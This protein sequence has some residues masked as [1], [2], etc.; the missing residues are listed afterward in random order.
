MK[1]KRVKAL[2]L[3][4]AVALTAVCPVA[5][6]AYGKASE[7]TITF[8]LSSGEKEQYYMDYADN[9]II[10]F[11]SEKEWGTGA[12][13]T[14]LDL[15]FDIASSTNPAD[16]FTT[17]IYGGDY[18]DVMDLSYSQTSVS[19]LYDEGIAMDIT[20]LVE[21]Y[22]PNY[23]ELIRSD[24]AVYREAVTIVDGEQRILQ[25]LG[26]NDQGKDMY[27]GL[28]YRRDWLVRF[29]EMPEYVW[30]NSADDILA[31]EHSERQGAAPEITNYFEASIAYGTDESAWNAGG[32]KKNE[33][34]SADGAE[35]W[36]A[37]QGG[38]RGNGI[39]CSYGDNAMD[40]YTDNLVFPS[41]TKDPVF[42]S[43]W[44]WMFQTF[45]EKVWNNPDYTDDSGNTINSDNAYMMSV[46]YLGSFTRG[47]FSSAFGGGSPFIYL[48]ADSGQLVSGLTS[49]NTRLYLEYIN[50]WYN[51]GWL[52]QDFTTRTSDVFYT[53][54][55][56]GQ[57]LGVIPAYI[58]RKASQLGNVLDNG[59]LALTKGIMVV[60]A[61]LPINDVIG[62]SEYRFVEPDTIYTEGKVASKYMVTTAAEDKNL[63]ALLS[64]FDYLYSEE[65]A[66]LASLGFDKAQY[67]ETKDE[68][69]TEYGLTD[70]AYYIDENATDG[71]IYKWAANN[72]EGSDLNSAAR[73]NRMGLG[74]H[75]IG[76][77]DHG[78]TNIEQ[79]TIDN[80]NR[81]PNT[82]DVM[83]EL[84]PKI[85]ADDTYNVAYTEM[86]EAMTKFLA[87]AIKTPDETTFSYA[88]GDLVN[89]A[90]E[91]TNTVRDYAQEA[92]DLYSNVQ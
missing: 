76:T 72:P 45:E 27:Q 24:P 6:T 57:L 37:G 75:Y 4:M 22:M 1:I 61:P 25:L 15:K 67:E 7:E 80:W 68:F 77:C 8:W 91:P 14:K 20:E 46:Y 71:R 88:W 64:F 17:L 89:A 13:A 55:S 92:Y 35:I 36:E 47:D 86:N 85:N 10:R 19:Q 87:A 79:W 31:M 21:E 56:A 23:M 59:S 38:E 3:C 34:Y 82:G 69:Y 66:R 74:L 52:D 73:I 5:I 12:D 42:L 9:P 29:G 40:T 30:A 70:G 53:I 39:I 44:E 58:G 2:F 51:R 43:D 50:G 33:L 65:G 32:W 49:E 78:Y 48:D 16:S 18:Q 62:E 41:G 90:E 60:G 11:L 83:T 28:M 81:Y 54:D 84:I 26:L 63:P